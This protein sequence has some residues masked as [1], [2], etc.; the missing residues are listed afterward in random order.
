[1]NFHDGVI[2]TDRIKQV[3][4]FEDLRFGNMHPTD[5]D[6]CIEYKDKAV[7]FLE[8]KLKDYDMPLGQQLCLERLADN[9]NQAGKRAIVL[10]CEHETYDVSEPVKAGSAIVRAMYYN[11]K[12]INGDGRN[13]KQYVAGFITYVK[14]ELK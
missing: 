10:L 14:G 7:I 3:I 8:Y 12:W 5:I 6:G 11:G 9:C 4:A 1:M 2:H 13:V